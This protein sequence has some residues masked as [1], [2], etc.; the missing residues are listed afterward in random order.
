[1]HNSQG[2]VSSNQLASFPSPAH[3]L[4]LKRLGTRLAVHKVMKISFLWGVVI[5]MK[6]QELKCLCYSTCPV[7]NGYHSMKQLRFTS[8][9]D[10]CLV[11]MRETEAGCL[12]PL[13][14]G[15]D[16][17]YGGPH[18]DGREQMMESGEGGWYKWDRIYSISSDQFST[19]EEWPT[20]RMEWYSVFSSLYLPCVQN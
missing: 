9:C 19:L 3:L 8:S 7:D 4:V 11:V 15:T 5:V 6:L 20:S 14:V 17:L 2:Q 12:T 18:L 10:Q 13:G 1:M 16:M